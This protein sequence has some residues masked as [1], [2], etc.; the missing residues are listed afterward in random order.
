MDERKNE[1][2]SCWDKRCN[3]WTSGGRDEEFVE[4][5]FFRNTAAKSLIFRTTLMSL[6]DCSPLVHRGLS[7]CQCSILISQKPISYDL[8][9]DCCENTFSQPSPMSFLKASIR[10]LYSSALSFESSRSS[11][12]PS[13][14][15]ILCLARR[16]ADRDMVADLDGALGSKDA[17]GASNRWSTCGG[18]EG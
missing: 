9:S 15:D 7:H 12:G 4:R 11:P 18:D 3:D 14:I 13:Y 5:I 17:G 2:E 6:S 1:E 10:L 16:M 8:I